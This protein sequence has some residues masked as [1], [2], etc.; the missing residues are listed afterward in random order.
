MED[1]VNLQS[2]LAEFESRAQYSPDNIYRH[3]KMQWRY[4]PVHPFGDEPDLLASLQITPE[5][6]KASDAWAEFG[7][8]IALVQVWCLKHHHQ[9]TPGL[10]AYPRKEPSLAAWD[11]V[12]ITDAPFITRVRFEEIMQAFFE[13]GFANGERF[14]GGGVGERKLTDFLSSAQR[15]ELALF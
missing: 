2:R 14:L 3:R 10:F 8:D 15:Q 11:L 9:D 1:L 6:C 4:L 12:A 13:L 7:V 5:D